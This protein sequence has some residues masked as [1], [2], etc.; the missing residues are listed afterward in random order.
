MKKI[1]TILALSL[2][3]AAF[4]QDYPHYSMFMY[5]K[6]VYNPGYA[7]SRNVLSINGAYRNQWSGIDGAPQDINL[8][9]DAPI[10]KAYS[11]AFHHVALGLA[12]NKETQGPITNTGINAYYA[13][14]I[15]MDKSVLS[16]GLQAGV[17]LYSA[18]YSELNAMDANDELLANDVKNSILPNFGAGAF[19]SSN[20]FYIGLSV[21]N[22][23]QNYYDKKQPT[24][25]DGKKAQQTRGYFLSGGYTFPVSEHI[26]LQPQCIIRYTG[27]GTYKL[28][29]NADIN[30]SAIIYQRVMIGATYR[31]DNSLEGIVHLQVARKFNIGYSYDYSMSDLGRYAKGAHE[32]SIGF[33]FIRDLKDYADPRFIQNF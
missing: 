7:G 32:I 16:L 26:A 31:T 4:S 19:W 33:D 2:P 25:L 29:V 9:I 18:R 23:L 27:N 30:L 28:P 6:L 22:I 10:G 3:V 24:Y 11:E 12:V 8:S 13:Y 5:N 14:R 20:R 21:P 1:F 15:K 17:N